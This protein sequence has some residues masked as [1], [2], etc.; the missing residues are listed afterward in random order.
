[1]WMSVSVNMGYGTDGSGASVFGG[2]NSAYSA[3]KNYFRYDNA[4]NRIYPENYST[5]EYRE[6]LQ[7]DLDNNQPINETTQWCQFSPR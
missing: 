5:S 1:M 6:I 3:M 4:V 7:G 2:N